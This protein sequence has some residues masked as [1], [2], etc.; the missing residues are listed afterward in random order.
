MQTSNMYVWSKIGSILRDWTYVSTWFPPKNQMQVQQRTLTVGG[1]ITVRLVTSFTSLDSTV[2][3][4]T[5][6]NI[7]YI[8]VKSN[9]AK[10]KTSHTV[11]LSPTVSILQFSLLMMAIYQTQKRKNLVTSQQK[12]SVFSLVCN[13]HKSCLCMREGQNILAIKV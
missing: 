1:S 9:L 10:M 11:I 2:S 7:F 6:N 12:H 13:I 4:P 3:L 8:S 5:N